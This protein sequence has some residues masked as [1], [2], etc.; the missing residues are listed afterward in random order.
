MNELIKLALEIQH[1]DMQEVG[2][3]SDYLGYTIEYGIQTKE[4]KLKVWNSSNHDGFNHK[5]V[6]NEIIPHL[7]DNEIDGSFTDSKWNEIMWEVTTR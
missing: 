5:E 3:F 1:R 2:R 4:L 7:L 6:L